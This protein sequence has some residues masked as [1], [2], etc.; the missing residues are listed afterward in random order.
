MPSGASVHAS[1]VLIGARAILIRGPS[2]CGKSRLALRLVQAHHA[3][4]SSFA[5]LIGDDRIHL[6]AAHGRL[7][8]RPAPALAGLIEVRG[9]GIRRMDYEPA[10]IVGLIVDLADERAERMPDVVASRIVIEGVA[11]PRISLPPACDPLV[12]I[13]AYLKSMVA[14]PGAT[15]ARGAIP[16]ISDPADASAMISFR[17]GTVTR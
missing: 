4:G 2:G 16:H 12:V 1:C 14:E 9:L 8:A 6:G 3:G 15:G 17:T 11:V 5:R 10:A 7:I 13:E